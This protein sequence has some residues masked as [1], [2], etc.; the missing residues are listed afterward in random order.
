MEHTVTVYSTPTCGYC[1]MAKE[2]L[3]SKGIAFEDVDL[4]QDR[5][6]AQ[7]VIEKTGQYAVP[8][9]DIDGEYIVGFDRDR[10]DS[11]LGLS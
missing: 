1:T 3:A 2:Y 11:L 8:V 5:A 10:I 4:S 7:T 9:I 6:R